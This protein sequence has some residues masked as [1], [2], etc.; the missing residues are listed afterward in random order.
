MSEKHLSRIALALMTLATVACSGG[1]SF[2]R[3][4]D[5]TTTFHVTDKAA[6]VLPGVA[7]CSG[8]SCATT[9][10]VGDAAL[11]LAPG[12]QAFVTFVVP[13]QSFTFGDLYIPNGLVIAVPLTLQ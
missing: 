7:V 11:A 4:A 1:G 12:V 13:G 5:T 6:R 3:P 10:A 8:S 2:A 9:N